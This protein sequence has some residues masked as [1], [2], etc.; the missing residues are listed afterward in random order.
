MKKPLHCLIL[1]GFIFV[2]QLLPVSAQSVN[3][4]SSSQA[5]A[6]RQSKKSISPAYFQFRNPVSVTPQN[7]EEWAQKHMDLRIEDGFQLIRSSTD[8]QGMEHFR[9]QQTYH[10][11]PV[12]GGIYMLHTKNGIAKSLNGDFFADLTLS[13][14]PTISQETALTNALNF[15]KADVYMWEIPAAEIALQIS[16]NDPTA[17]Y[18]PQGELVIA[19][20]GK[21]F[22]P[23][24]FR[25]LWKF[26]IYAHAPFDRSW[27]YVDA[28]DGSIF[29]EVERFHHIDAT[30][31]AQTHYSG[32]QTIT[33]DYNGS[34]YRL[35]ELGR[36]QGIETYDLNQT[37]NFW[38]AVDFTDNDNNWNNV[39]PQQDEVATD[40][41]WGAEMT[42]DYFMQKFN[43]NSINGVGYKLQSYVHY[44][45][46]YNNAVWDGQRMIYGDGD[47][48]TWNP[49][50]CLDAVG[51]EITHGLTQF[52]S[53]LDTRNE[54]GA[55][56][57]AFS[58]IFA[59]AIDFHTRP[60]AANWT[61][62]EE[63]KVNGIGIRDLSNPNAMNHPDTYQGTHW[64]NSLLNI[65]TNSTVVSHWFY[66]MATGGSGTND[67]GDSYNVS[68]IG[69]DKAAQIAYRTN[70]Y[71]LSVFSD[72]SDARF[73]SI[74]AAIDLFGACSPEVFACAD[75]WYAVGVGG[76]YTGTVT[77]D[78][79]AIGREFC[80]GPATVRF[81]NNSINAGTFH[82]DFG[83]GTTSTQRDPVH[84]YTSNG[85]YT[86]TLIADAGL[87]G[88]DTMTLVD[89]VKIDPSLPC[90]INLDPF[91]QNVTQ[92]GCTGNLYDS[93]GPNGDYHNQSV[94]F[95]QLAPTAATNVT[96]SFSSFDYLAGD[97][98]RIYDGPSL[99]SPLL[100]K[101]SG[102]NLPNG[103]TIVSTS[104][105]VTILHR[106]N[107]YQTASGFAM[108][109]SCNGGTTTPPVPAFTVS[110]Q[111]PCGT[112]VQFTDQ[113]TGTPTSW[114]W[115]FGNGVTS[116]LQNPVYVYTQ[117]G[118]YDVSLTVTNA[119]GSTSLV[120][121]NLIVVDQPTAAISPN[122]TVNLCS[123]ASTTLTASGGTSFLWSDGSTSPSINVNQAGSYSVTTTS[124]TG[125]TATSS[126]VNVQVAN[127][128]ATISPG[129]S[130]GLCPGQSITISANSGSS[131]L[132]SDGST[133]QD[134]IV[135]QAGTFSVTVTD[136]F[137]CTA[138]STPVNVVQ[139]SNPVVTIQEGDTV[140]D[141]TNG[142]VTL[143]ATGGNLYQWS[144]GVTG[145]T[146]TVSGVGDYYVVGSNQF[147]CADTSASTHVNQYTTTAV[148]L[149]GGNTALCEGE[150]VNLAVA[151][152][153]VKYAWTNG[154]TTSNITV[155][156]NGNYGVVVTDAN[157][158][159]AVATPVPVTVNANPIAEFDFQ[160]G[161]RQVNF[162]DQSTPV[163][164]WDW[165]FGDGNTA[166]AQ[167]PS[168]NYAVNGTYNV[169]LEVTQGGCINSK[170]YLVSVPGFGTTSIDEPELEGDLAQTSV[171]PNPFQDQMHVKTTFTEGGDISLDITDLMGRPLIHLFEGWVPAGDFQYDWT[172]PAELPAG[173]YLFQIKRGEAE[174]VRRVV[175]M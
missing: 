110:D 159:E 26:D 128:V 142:Q 32:S 98:L 115:D 7:L 9:M 131:Y 85:N 36:G 65:H 100:G 39:N 34:F 64:D 70:T 91:N 120:Q 86:V 122:G 49:V 162:L 137:G 53:S 15:L 89:Y 56:N 35:R 54:A 153:G 94:S 41:H 17:S 43:R 138:T 10:G 22:G 50:V 42:Y 33:A 55:L 57:E 166:S 170:E 125:C 127:P 93:G 74:Q 112:P 144:N 23:N 135:S 63:A 81:Y 83:D 116:T 105:V 67:N 139:Y 160:V 154:D 8:V 124:A 6:I 99:A 71:Y 132:W 40:A 12:E 140:N 146:I 51:H 150:T 96:L 164:N 119:G 97:T 46:G 19:S 60:T 58:D 75:A 130:L 107:L 104:G 174:W 123:G 1:L 44:N 167:N 106:S 117:N 21:N 109:W 92:T 47:G 108:S 29:Q 27:V 143:T 59:V 30:G 118:S 155:G 113:S 157:G 69:I 136:A 152:A 66:R 68:G 45:V 5:V 38:A 151:P 76:V 73:Y 62:A 79:N 37:P 172:A 147:G 82:W 28:R 133:A 24:D 111:T 14:T 61:I 31:T 52:T 168:H 2:T 149:P 114:L 156:L 161:V 3:T 16:Q 95:I 171:W 4:L 129:G 173:V 148:I 72:F 90:N 101:F 169:K 145:P 25:L 20:D 48:I 165:D 141:C 84:L 87:C 11:V 78:F 134:L 77:A 102:N 126:P 18:Y 158:C 121:Q 103:G 13:V 163:S 88:S 175:R 80:Q